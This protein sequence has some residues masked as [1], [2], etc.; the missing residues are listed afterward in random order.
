MAKKKT[1]GEL[2]G[3]LKALRRSGN[4]RL[5]AHEA[6]MD[7][8]TVYDRRI[9]DP[10][11]AARLKAAL[12]AG[13]ANAAAGKARRATSNAPLVARKTRHGTQLVRAAPG[14]WS[15]EV[16]AAFRATLRLTGC[17]RAAARACGLSTNALYERRGNYPGFAA[18]WAEDEAVARERVPALLSAAAIA[19]LDPEIE[20][21]A[22]PKVD[23]DQ[24]IAIARLKCGGGAA[25][26]RGRWIRK[27]PT[28]E[29]V[30][31]EVLRRIA[32]IKAHRE[33]GQNP[34][35]FDGE[36]RGGAASPP[37]PGGSASPPHPQPLPIKGRGDDEDAGEE[38]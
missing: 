23:V 26:R 15:D 27:E 5:A 20:D 37:A 13:K 16:E 18:A 3:F 38:R 17:V 28:S 8:G 25:G 35:P 1:A 24:A 12:A 21:R 34:P 11:F 31:D 9:K 10:A 7:A 30:R 4:I 33:R 29:E 19:S 2:N 22:L 6:G 14:R 32:A 36:G